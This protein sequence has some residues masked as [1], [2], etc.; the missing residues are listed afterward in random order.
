VTLTVYLRP[1]EFKVSM[2][3]EVLPW[4]T[5]IQAAPAQANIG[6]SAFHRVS[7][8]YRAMHECEV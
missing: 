1:R 2:S 3:R 5:R 6:G 4:W 8:A 7:L